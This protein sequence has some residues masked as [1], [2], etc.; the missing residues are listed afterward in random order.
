VSLSLRGRLPLCRAM[1]G[2]EVRSAARSRAVEGWSFCRGKQLGGGVYDSAKD[3]PFDY[4][5]LAKYYHADFTPACTKSR[6]GCDAKFNFHCER[7]KI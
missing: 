4:L 6:A 2:V 7:G 3:R 5:S 1:D